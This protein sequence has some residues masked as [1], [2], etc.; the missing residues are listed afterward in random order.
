M[1]RDR[2]GRD[3]QLIFSRA[4]WRSRLLFYLGVFCCFAPVGLLKEMQTLGAAPTSYLVAQGLFSGL[5]AVTWAACAIHARRWIPIVIL[6]TFGS[7]FVLKHFF[8]PPALPE[9]L[10]SDA[11]V[12]LKGRLTTM[13]VATMFVVDLAYVAFVMFILSEG[14][15]SFGAYTEIRLAREVHASLVPVT[16]GT[17]DG[18]T[19]R[20][21]SRPSGDVGG[22]LVD[23][24]TENGDFFGCVADVTGHGVAAGVLMG[25]F[26]TA[27]HSSL[28]DA[29]DLGDLVTR[30]NGT[31]CPLTQP[32]MFVTCACVH[33]VD[34]GRIEYVLAGHPSLLHVSKRMGTTAWVGE[35]QLAVALLDHV[36][37]ETHALDVEP[38]DL[39]IVITD[40]LIE[41]FD[42]HDHELGADGLAAAV[43]ALPASSTLEEIEGAIFAAVQRH[44]KQTDDQTLLLIRL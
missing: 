41:V 29:K 39:I 19:W 25:M 9:S 27:V 17:S 7:F 34:T 35:Q 3:L 43:R 42:S 20:G 21:V 24:V 1:P 33:V 12:S 30:V 18:V 36:D 11:I 5:L 22:D 15:R 14:R 31:L 10:S 26:K 37:Y 28:P 2:G 44:G 32:N 38:G 6:A 40:G 8:P 13:A 16:A 23:V 4:P